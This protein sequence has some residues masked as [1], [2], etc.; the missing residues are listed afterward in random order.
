MF[1]PIHVRWLI[2]LYDHFQNMPNL[3]KKRIEQAGITDDLNIELEAE[4][5]FEDLF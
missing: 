2:S 5:P 1:K 4:D 3:K